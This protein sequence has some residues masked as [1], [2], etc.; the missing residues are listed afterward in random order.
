MTKLKTLKNPWFFNL[1]YINTDF[2][3]SSTVTPLES[4]T[5]AH[6]VRDT[7]AT[8]N[9]CHLK[10][11]EYFQLNKI[12]IYSLNF[13]ILKRKHQTTNRSPSRSNVQ[14]IYS[15]L[16]WNCWGVR[17]LWDRWG[18]QLTLNFWFAP[19][20]WFRINYQFLLEFIILI[21]NNHKSF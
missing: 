19:F 4:F 16:W 17:D 2:S 21:L 7:P 9:C 10:S 3:Q 1:F 11:F 18:L 14:T 20:N 13:S 5:K 8:L 15:Y 12:F 6:R